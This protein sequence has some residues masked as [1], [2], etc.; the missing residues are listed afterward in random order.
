MEE[1][2]RY[3]QYLR[4]NRTAIILLSVLSCFISVLVVAFS[5]FTK[6]VIDYATDGNL[7]LIFAIVTGV[8]L[9]GEVG[10]KYLYSYLMSLKIYKTE[11]VIK[12]QAFLS[13]LKKDYRQ[14]EEIEDGDVLMR[15]TS[16]C[17]VIAE[18]TISYVP[19]FVALL[20]RIIISLAVL[21]V[22]DPLFAGCLLGVGIIIY[23]ATLFLR[24]RNKT[25]H[26]NSQQAEGEVLSFYK[27]GISHSF[28][29]KLF[30][31]GKYVDER[32]DQI[33]AKYQ[34]ARMRH[35]SFNIFV[36][37]GFLL[38]MRA[39]YLI[40]IIWAVMAI[41]QGGSIGNLFLMV[42]LI[43]Q[44]EGPFSSISGLIP[45]YYRTLGSIERV[46][47][48]EGKDEIAQI[49]L[50]EF[51]APIIIDDITFSYGDEQ[52]PLK[53]VSLTIEPNDFIAIVGGSGCG[54]STLLKCI[55]GMYKPS[56][57][58]VTYDGK[59]VR[60]CSALFSYVPQGNFLLP[61]TIKE[62]L[63]LF[64][65]DAT[66]E[67]IERVLNLTMLTAKINSL[68]NGLQSSVSDFGAG[69]SEGEG[70]RL[71]IARALLVDR[72]VLVLDECTSALDE[73]TE[74]AIMDNIISL[75][76]TV[77]LVSHKSGAVAYAS[78]VFRLKKEET[79][80]SE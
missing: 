53:N 69:L 76:K 64:S 32:C 20:S 21:F 24:R 41:T 55:M 29:F 8:L 42:Q 10:L 23:F 33:Q 38:F 4:E 46:F 37:S 54:K 6:L 27:E 16:D 62:N 44:I 74:K 9:L 66:K 73:A 68:P 75:G 61:G 43:A 47:A 52:T 71:S 1:K 25:L 5:Y 36:N 15:L 7:F 13:Y 78:K 31:N 12:K 39:S 14:A 26:K 18:G 19:E 51:N 58:S 59:D 79:E 80:E 17:R 65:P 72:P 60:Q 28:L 50:T 63:C 22:I 30:G 2:Q 35:A 77:L 45:Q 56:Q 40:A 48:L 70:Q 34:T 3:R 11:N 67:Q 49:N 57:G